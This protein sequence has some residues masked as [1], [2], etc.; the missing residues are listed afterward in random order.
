MIVEEWTEAL[1][2]AVG[3]GLLIGVVLA[4]VNSWRV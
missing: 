2:F 1:G 4:F 3:T